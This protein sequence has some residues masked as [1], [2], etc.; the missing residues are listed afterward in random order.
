MITSVTPVRAIEGGRVALVGAG[1]RT[2]DL[3]SVTVGD[4]PSRAVFA[5]S[6]KIVVAIPSDL[7]GGPTPIRIDDHPGETVLVTVGAPWATGL[8]QV[9]NPVFDPS[10]NL[11]VTYSGSRGQ[12][13]PVSIFRVTAAGTREPFASGIVNATSMAVGVGAC[14]PNPPSAQ[15]ILFRPCEGVFVARVTDPCG[16][17]S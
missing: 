7:E 1:F 4:Q 12:E 5:S 16:P 15:I 13:A 8:H 9:D 17:A 6:S 3:P 10:G 2:E 14:T 11:F